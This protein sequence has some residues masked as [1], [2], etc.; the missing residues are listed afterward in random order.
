MAQIHFNTEDVRGGLLAVALLQ[1]E[2]LDAVAN[3]IAMQ[4]EQRS[5]SVW[6]PLAR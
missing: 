5:G 2:L 1:A 6:L 3:L 4:P